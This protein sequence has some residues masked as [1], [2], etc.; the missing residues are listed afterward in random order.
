MRPSLNRLKGNLPT[1]PALAST[2]LHI[3]LTGIK[4]LRLL[5]ADGSNFFQP[6]LLP[7]F[8]TINTYQWY[9]ERRTECGLFCE[10]ILEFQ[11]SRMVVCA[12]VCSFGTGTRTHI[13][14]FRIWVCLLATHVIFITQ[15]NRIWGKTP[16]LKSSKN[17]MMYTL[18]KLSMFHFVSFL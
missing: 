2:Q 10:H 1:Y 8:V 4:I 7:V 17:N 18:L 6:F 15:G 16:E 12:H 11:W 9:G 3:P 14:V 13:G 5:Q